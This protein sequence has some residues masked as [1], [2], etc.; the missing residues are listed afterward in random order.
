MT[1]PL[2]RSPCVAADVEVVRFLV[3]KGLDPKAL[4]PFAQREGFARYDLP[5]TDYLMSNAST[6][7]QDLLGTA[8][9]WQPAD[10][11]ARWIELGANVNAGASPAQYS[12]RLS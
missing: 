1:R 12:E 10:R 9:T 11:I 2:C 6:A 5:T 3:E 7:A 8:A 4:S